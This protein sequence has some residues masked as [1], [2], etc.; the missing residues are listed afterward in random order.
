LK[1]DIKRFR[2]FCN[3]LSVSSK[4]QGVIRLDKLLGTQEYLLQEVVRGLEDDIHAFVCCKARQLGIT[5]IQLA[6]DLFWHYE[7]TG[8]QGTLASDGE[9]NKEMF[10]STLTQF[11]NGLPR[12]HRLRLLTNNR[13]MLEFENGSRMFMQI[14]GG[15]KRKGGKGRGKGITFIHATECSSWEDEESLASIQSSLAEIN[16]LRFAMWES[17]ARGFNLF[18]DMY[19]EAEDAVTQ[20]AIFIG[21]WRNEL[22]RKE[23]GSNEYE[24]Y[25]DG[26]L[27]SNEH[28]WSQAVK[29]QYDFD[30]VPE[31]I[32]W[33]RWIV[34]E[35][36]H[37]QD[38][39]RQEMPWTAEMSFI[40]TG[41]NFFSLTRVHEIA[42]AIDAEPAPVECLRFGFGSDFMQTVVEGSPEPRAQLRIWEQPDDAAFYSIG[43]DPAYGSAHWADRSVVEVYRCYAD[44]FEQVAEFCTPEITTYK[45]AW[46]ICYIAGCYRNSMVNLE[47]NG[48]GEAV[49]GEIDNLRR[50][51]S[52][53]GA[54]PQGKAIRDVVGHMRYFLYRR[55]DSPFGGGVYGWKCLALDTPLPT[56]D[57]WTTMGK[58]K[59]DDTLFDDEGMPCRV[60]VAHP[61]LRDH[62]CYRI[63]F[64]DGSSI[65]ADADHLWELSGGQMCST[66]I[67]RE[68]DKIDATAPLFAQDKELP[69]HPY[70][71]GLWLGDGHSANGR[72]SG[73]KEDLD[74]IIENITDLGLK[75]SGYGKDKRNKAC[76]VN[77]V[78]LAAE[79][80]KQ[81]MINNKHIPA[82]Y[83]R[84]SFDQRL[85]LL[86][87]LMD[88]DGSITT[89]RKCTFTTTS[90]PLR[91]GFSELLRTLGVRS[92]YSTRTRTLLYKGKQVECAESYQFYF[93]SYPEMP[94]FR[95]LR[96]RALMNDKDNRHGKSAYRPFRTKTHLIVSVEQVESVPV[97]C[98]E[99]DSKSHLYLAGESMV[100]T[101]NT[102][103]ETKD[104][105]FNTFRD[106]VD[107]GHAVLHSK[108][109]A[110]EMKI[111]VREKDG[112]LGAS[113]RGHDDCTVASAIAAENHVRY[114]IMKLKQMGL[115]WA[116][117]A[118]KRAKVAITGRAETPV[119][120]TLRS[121]VGGYM[122]KVGI[123]YGVNK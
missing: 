81:N 118:D 4:E 9:E 57:G 3:Q 111:I 71:L 42:T 35:K 44:R 56:P 14:G 65:V 70:V 11:H 63:T 38:Y 40:L 31:Q 76:R 119:E 33:W 110:D 115:T 10:R 24:A 96:K 1:F 32:A 92:H 51:A 60:V 13:N 53:L 68:G 116:K 102:T 90:I 87:G 98:I 45:F 12:T 8:M 41:K 26:K 25:W 95:L 34:A 107:K 82:S 7:Y 88:T 121:T 112:F 39:A 93:V 17:T 85:S 103:G 106:L 100:P 16:P 22:Y 64:S 58:V 67:L 50:Q 80:A 109:L 23:K 74:S 78:G 83:L 94:M 69:I 72:I 114:F 19:V 36:L 2:A 49:L 37:D 21:W 89:G 120:S 86:Q 75:I 105:A 54:S 61:V 59:N 5:T 18:H 62:Q 46:V 27:T 15:V 113:G 6:I 43:A 79:L 117:E 20:R 104:R 84:A 101:H 108:L 29:M 99:V 77:V 52:M 73:A 30:I 66:W 48:P 91:D 123:R 55:L 47:I 97:R 28:E 122:D